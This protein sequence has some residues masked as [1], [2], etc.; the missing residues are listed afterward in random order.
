MLI[1]YY[2]MCF[3]KHKGYESECLWHLHIYWHYFDKKFVAY[4]SCFF[5]HFIHVS[6]KR[7]E[8]FGTQNFTAISYNFLKAWETE[9]GFIQYVQQVSCHFVF[10]GYSQ[11]ISSNFKS[12][13]SERNVVS[14]NIGPQKISAYQYIGWALFQS[15][16]SLGLIYKQGM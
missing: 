10:Q 4:I 12:T 9:E 16:I 7:R 6:S 11:K 15:L 8:T 2:H 3:Y 1:T 5:G 14:A 13:V